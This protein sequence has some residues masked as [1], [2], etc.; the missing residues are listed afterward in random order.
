M[1]F[2]SVQENSSISLCNVATVTGSSDHLQMECNQYKSVVSFV[3]SLVLSAHARR[4]APVPS[5]SLS[6]F[7]IRSIL[8]LE[9]DVTPAPTS[10]GK[11]NLFRTPELHRL[12]VYIMTYYSEVYYI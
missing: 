9:I 2:N 1:R 5:K 6:D 8:G 4:L 7:T 10:S 3:D 11:L 12:L